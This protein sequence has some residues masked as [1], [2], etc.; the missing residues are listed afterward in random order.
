MDRVLD[1]AL[2]VGYRTLSVPF[3]PA[4][5]KR[6]GGDAELDDK[7]IAQILWLA[8]TTFSRQRRIKAA[9]S[10]LIMVRASEPPI[11][12]RRSTLALFELL[13]IMLSFEFRAPS[14]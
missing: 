2:D 1:P 12:K 14:T 5:V 6:F 8:L 3:V 4:S 13:V 7:V 9:S 10:A 11:N